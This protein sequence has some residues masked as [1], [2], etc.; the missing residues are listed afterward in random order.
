[1]NKKIFILILIII[2]ISG[3]LYAEQLSK[4]GIVN[5][6]RI[7]DDYFA[8]SSA[9]RE[10]SA[11]QEKYNDGMADILDEINDL[12]MQKLEAEN[13]GDDQKVLQIDA[14]IYSKQEYAKEFHSV[15]TN[16]INAKKQG[17]AQSSTFTAEILDAIT[18]IA[19]S[20]GYSMIMRTQDPDI[21]WYNHEIDITDLVLERLQW[22][23]ARENN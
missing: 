15:M 13:A 16:R 19:E 8:E 6:S 5:F 3:S 11:I 12:K 1:M 10:I 9:W 4:I 22:Q 2:S 7:V 18:Y 23:A 14:Q 20:E 21:L 17:L